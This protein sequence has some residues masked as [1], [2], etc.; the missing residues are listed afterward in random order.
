M[1]YKRRTDKNHVEIMWAL[2]S[3]GA[4]VYSTHRVGQGYP[5]LTVGFR[6]KNYLIEVKTA[7]GDLTR[8]EINF[9]DS[10]AGQVQVATTVDEA[11][12]IIGAIDGD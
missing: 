12:A 10:W 11:L 1:A 6:G 7:D 8:D 9:F 3:V 4:S 2:R 5:D